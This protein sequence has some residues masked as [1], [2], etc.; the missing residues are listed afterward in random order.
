MFLPEPFPTKLNLSLTSS[1]FLLAL[2]Y[3]VSVYCVSTVV[4]LLL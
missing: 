4:G 2:A 3:P 1:P